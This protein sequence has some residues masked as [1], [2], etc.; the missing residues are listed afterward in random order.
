[1]GPP[2]QYAARFRRVSA[3]FAARARPYQDDA[4][5]QRDLGLVQLLAGEVD[6]GAEALQISVGLEPGR[7]SSRFLLAMARGTVGRGPTQRRGAVRG[8][9]RR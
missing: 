5:M 4:G 8:G 9:D 6:L 7:P 1:M 2:S 3:E